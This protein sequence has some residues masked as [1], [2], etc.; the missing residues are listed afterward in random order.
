MIQKKKSPRTY[1]FNYV[2]YLRLLLRLEFKNSVDG[3]ETG[4]KKDCVCI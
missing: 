1:L 4:R 2:N 3:V